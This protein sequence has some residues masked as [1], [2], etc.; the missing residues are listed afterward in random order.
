MDMLCWFKS[1]EGKGREGKGSLKGEG[2]TVKEKGKKRWGSILHPR[3]ELHFAIDFPFD[4]P[5]VLGPW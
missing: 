2:K 5:L 1:E 4:S 3:A